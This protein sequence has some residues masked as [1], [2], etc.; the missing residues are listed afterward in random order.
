M[1]N[2]FQRR[3]VLWLLLAGASLQGCS[4]TNPTLYTLAPVAGTPRTGGPKTVTLRQ[5]GLA[6]YLERSQIVRSAE[7]YQLD[8]RANEWWGEPLGSMIARV[9][10]EDLTQ[11]LAGT[12]VYSENGVINADPNATV[13]VNI[14]RMDA[15]AAGVVVLTAQLAVTFAKLHRPMLTRT[16]SISVRPASPG[17]RG[18]VSA[19]S[20]ALG[21]IADAVAAMLIDKS[22]PRDTAADHRTFVTDRAM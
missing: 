5:I 10:V 21:Q 9:L 19:M 16:V 22:R 13:E 6:R 12:S 17:L 2:I 3:D 11:R 8:V 7:N 20:A 14:Q 1:S 15:D 18:E 4:S